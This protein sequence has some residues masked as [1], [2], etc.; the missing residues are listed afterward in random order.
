MRNRLLLAGVVTLAAL[1]AVAARADAQAGK[2]PRLWVLSPFSATATAAWHEAFRQGLRDLGWV[3]GKNIAVEYR[4][5][6]G[7][8]SRLAE[9]AADVVRLN[10]DVIVTATATDAL[11]ARKLTQTIPIVVASSGDPVG[12]GLVASLARPGGNVTGLSQIAPETGGKRLDLLKEIVPHLSRV[13][14]LWNP[15]G[16]V[17]TLAWKEIQ[18]PARQ[19]G[20]ELVSLEAAAPDDFARRFEEA[21]RARAGALAVMLSPIF[22][23]NLR[24]LADLAIRHR[25]PT[26]FHL[27][28][29]VESS[30]LMAYGPDRSEM[31]RRAA[32]F[33][34][35]ILKGAKPATLPIEPPTK[36][37][38][39]INLKTAKALGLTMPQSL[40]LRADHVLQ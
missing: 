30:G 15:K 5:A 17:S 2:V 35:S 4:Y 20:I 13:A 19:L 32:V 22:A 11:A 29:F 39:A 8:A 24:R 28:E 18:L 10:V 31:F 16:E 21:T 23:G 27:R 9:I 1:A 7:G 12:S 25:L 3:D 40:L 14:V 38:L 33:V 26:T 34:D 6:D 37:E 36:F